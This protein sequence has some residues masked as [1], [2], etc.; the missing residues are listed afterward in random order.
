MLRNESPEV[1]LNVLSLP[2]LLSFSA[3]SGKMFFIQYLCANTVYDKIMSTY[4]PLCIL[5]LIMNTTHLAC[6]PDYKHKEI[7][8]PA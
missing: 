1:K 3:Q 5:Y 4:K 2:N 7:D 6:L 8:N